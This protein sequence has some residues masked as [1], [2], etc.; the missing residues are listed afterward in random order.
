MKQRFEITASDMARLLASKNPKK[1][2]T[3][4]VKRRI[5]M[6]QRHLNELIHDFS[7][8]IASK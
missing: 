4:I 3:E 8:I 5:Q 2:L 1:Q 7:Q 6:R